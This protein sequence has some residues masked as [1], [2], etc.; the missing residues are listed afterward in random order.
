MNRQWMPVVTGV[1]EIVA[2]V[3]AGIGVCALIFSSLMINTVPDIQNDP[4]VPL[5]L[6][7]VLLIGIAVFVGV[8]GLV[9]L[10]GGIFAVRRRG[11]GWALAGSI[12]AIFIMPPAGILALALVMFGES[13]FE[14]R[15]LDS[16][17]TRPVAL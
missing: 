7:T 17:D 14:G 11:W 1:L 5:E 10:V 6:I 3:S 8:F 9:S 2:A 12:A 4:D 13:E 15:S 16:A